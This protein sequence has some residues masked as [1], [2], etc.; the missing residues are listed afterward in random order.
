V[1]DGEVVFDIKVS[2][3]GDGAD[4]RARERK[5]EAPREDPRE[6]KERRDAERA[7]RDFQKMVDRQEA[8][9]RHN[10]LKRK[11][12]EQAKELKAVRE[13]V[14]RH[15]ET[16][17]QATGFLRNPAGAVG[18]QVLQMLGR[19]GPWG[20]AAAAAITAIATGPEVMQRLVR[21]LGRKGGPL[22][23]DW[24]RNIEEEVNGA[25][26]LRQQKDR[27]LGIDPFIVGAQGD[28]RPIDGTDIYNSLYRRGDVRQNKMGQDAQ[29]G[30]LY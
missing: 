25:L 17:G 8:L 20:A 10:E 30:G 22:N 16:L 4:G 26:D 29:V 1:A 11:V 3:G 12:A 27:Q 6:R 23:R 9:D 24:R 18:G 5:K 21:E 2:V 13:I 14:G 15:N 7:F 19:F 28:F